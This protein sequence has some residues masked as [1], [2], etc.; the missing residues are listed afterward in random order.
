M[1]LDEVN[2]ESVDTRIE[3]LP[4]SSPVVSVAR[5]SH[6]SDSS[7]EDLP[8][9]ASAKCLRDTQLLGDHVNESQSALSR[10]E[11]L[12]NTMG[13]KLCYEHVFSS[14]TQEIDSYVLGTVTQLAE[15]T[16]GLTHRL[17]RL[18]FGPVLFSC[19]LC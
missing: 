16:Q 9:I 4:G 1:N 10:H 7:T 2:D 19:L 3:A 15:F 17:A 8:G 13:Q 12:L 14:I 11:S 6:S 18:L 5:P